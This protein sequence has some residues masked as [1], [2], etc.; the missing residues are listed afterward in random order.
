MEKRELLN[1]KKILTSKAV[2]LGLVL[3]FAVMMF[4]FPNE[5]KFKYD[6][7]RGRAWLYETL[8]AP[9][10]F[11]LLK[12][13]AELTEERNLVAS[14]V[15]P[16]YNYDESVLNRVLHRLSISAN[17]NTVSDSIIGII[18][19]DLK[20]VYQKG[21]M[22]VRS[23]TDDENNVAFNELD[24]IFLQRSNS[25]SEVLESYVYDQ[26]KAYRYI[27]ANLRSVFPGLNADSLLQRLDIE[28]IIEPNLFYDRA[29]TEM[30]HKDAVD[31]IS[32]TKGMI[33]TGQLIVSNGE[34]VT[35]EIEQILDSYKAEY[36]LNMGYSGNKWELI[37]AHAIFLLAI[38]LSLFIAVYLI[39]TSLFDRLNEFYFIL[40]LMVFAFAITAVVHNIS[41]LYMFFIPYSVFALYM[42]AF[43]R[44]KIIFPIYTLMILPLLIIDENGMKLFWLNLFAG[45]IAI[46]SFK[47]LNR[48]WLQFM[49]ALMIYIAMIVVEIAFRLVESEGMAGFDITALYLFLNALFI[50]ATYPLVY[51]LE[52]I[53]ML[54]SISTLRDLSDTNSPL[55]QELAKKAPGTFQHSLQVANLAERAV[56]AIHGNATLVKVGALYHDVGKMNNPQCFIENE[57][58]GIHYHA[59][60]SLIESAQ[61]IIKHVPDG[62]ELAKKYHL[63]QMVIDFIT[64]HHGQSQTLYFYNKYCNDGG[65]PSQ[66][67][68]FTYKGTLPTTCEQVTVMMA[69]AVEAASRSLKD[70]S[71]ESISELV[72]RILSQRISDSQLAM[73]DISIREINIIKDVFKKH[74]GEIYH[75][76]IVYPKKEEPDALRS[77]TVDVEME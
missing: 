33:Y 52:K 34:I 7:Q 53:F 18:S 16:Y 46:I 75:A 32:P 57:A 25:N 59:T 23:N 42:M 44:S 66:I 2:Y 9:M 27:E 22:P 28:N 48:G 4:I 24:L 76:R 51:L 55:L 8:T 62:A 29:T 11:P 45:W 39:D 13:P 20:S 71:K 69:D 74:L 38:L 35:A 30:L 37:L 54:V 10:D 26:P 14:K 64:S 19:D 70:Y 40:F 67:D 77:V 63:P 5:G 68:K 41:S 49:N 43:F 73:A 1:T 17:R 50:V 3:A 65:D 36:L 60:L 58:P 15:I 12:T 31:Y 6:Y 21:V 47:F 56:A 61:M 72:D